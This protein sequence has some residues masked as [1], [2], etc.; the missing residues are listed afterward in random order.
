MFAILQKLKEFKDAVVV[1]N[2]KEALVAAH[3]LLGW[4]LGVTPIPTLAG[5]ET[6]TAQE[7][8]AM[9]DECVGAVENMG[10]H[11]PSAGPGFLVLLEALKTLAPLIAK[12]IKTR[13]V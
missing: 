4:L 13:E 2:V 6:C 11:P 12:L 5:G 10:A 8:S 3:T 7:V 1:G 9:A